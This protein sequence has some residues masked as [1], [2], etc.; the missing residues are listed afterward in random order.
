MAL[1]RCSRGD[2]AVVRYCEVLHYSSE[3]PEGAIKRTRLRFEQEQQRKNA[4]FVI[5]HDVIPIEWVKA[6]GSGPFEK[7]P[8][9]IYPDFS[10]I[11]EWPTRDL[12]K[13]IMVDA[14]FI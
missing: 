2:Y 3:A 12:K 7:R 11:K 5:K 14:A 1:F 6:L 8:P 13:I 10:S 4:S 9:Y